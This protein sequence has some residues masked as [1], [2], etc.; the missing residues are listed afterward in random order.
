MDI[1]LCIILQNPPAGVD[2]GIQ[3]GSGNRYETIQTQ[4]SDGL[5][6][7]FNLTIQL[8]SDPQKINDPRF[9]G[10]FVQGQ[11]ASQFLYIDVGEYAGQVGGWSRRVK[12]PLSGVTWDMITQLGHHSTAFLITSFPGTAKDGSPICAT[13]KPFEGWKVNMP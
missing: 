13:V 2:F 3:K 6:I 12:V 4:R 1:Q 7:Q 5:D 9:S 11:P 10:P 8:K